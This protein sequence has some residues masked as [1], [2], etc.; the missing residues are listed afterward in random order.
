MSSSWPIL[1]GIFAV[2]VGAIWYD[3]T[4]ASAGGHLPGAPIPAA[5]P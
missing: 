3:A 4:I 1:L 2:V 5:H